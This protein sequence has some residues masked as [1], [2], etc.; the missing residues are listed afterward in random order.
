MGDKTTLQQQHERAMA[1]SGLKIEVEQRTSA[2]DKDMKVRKEEKQDHKTDIAAVRSTLEERRMNPFASGGGARAVRVLRPRDIRYGHPG[3]WATSS[4]G[5]STRP[6]CRRGWRPRRASWR[7]T[8]CRRT[9][10]RSGRSRMRARSEGV[11]CRPEEE[12]LVVRGEMGGRGTTSGGRQA[13]EDAQGGEGAARCGAGQNVL[14]W[15]KGTKLNKTLGWA[16]VLELR[17]IT[18]EPPS[19]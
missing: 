1:I 3:R 4:W 6:R 11:S 16:T 7:T 9:S 8:H 14:Q 13:Q 17:T 15:N 5:A 19:L 2:I 12:K 10:Q 18:I